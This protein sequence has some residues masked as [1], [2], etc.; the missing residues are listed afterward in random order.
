MKSNQISVNSFLIALLLGIAAFFLVFASIG[1]QLAAHITG[2]NLIYKLSKL[3][4]VDAEQN[5][6]TFFS[7]FLLLLRYKQKLCLG[8]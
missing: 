5:I 6:P 1:V 2:H 7:T 3:F 4:Y 8:R